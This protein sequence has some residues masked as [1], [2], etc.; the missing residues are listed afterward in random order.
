MAR[1]RD[2][3]LT[4]PLVFEITDQNVYQR[5]VTQHHFGYPDD[6]HA[7]GALLEFMESESDAKSISLLC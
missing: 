5:V 3:Q 2:H 7:I 6:S 4:R 1:N